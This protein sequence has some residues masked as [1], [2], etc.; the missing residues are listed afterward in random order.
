MKYETPEVEVTTFDI[1]VK[2]DSVGQG[3][4]GGCKVVTPDMDL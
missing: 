3:G 2:G 4:G 1:T